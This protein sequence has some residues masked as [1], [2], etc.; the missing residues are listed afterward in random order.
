MPELERRTGRAICPRGASRPA[1]GLL[2]QALESCRVHH[3]VG[4]PEL[5]ATAAGDDSGAGAVGIDRLAQ[6]RDV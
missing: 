6:A 2:D 4:D 1:R 5:V 3:V